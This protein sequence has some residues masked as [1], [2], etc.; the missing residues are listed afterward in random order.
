MSDIL[1]LPAEELYKAELEAL[2][3]N[4]KDPVP[5]GWKMSP[6]SVLT[7]I[8]GGKSGNTVITPKYMATAVSLRYALR[9]SSPTAPSC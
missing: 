4:E 7:Y 6:R 3:K 5:T 8:M 9:P 1:R 2:I